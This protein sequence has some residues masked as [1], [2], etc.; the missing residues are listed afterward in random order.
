M[1]TLYPI[2]PYKKSSYG[3]ENYLILDSESSY[4]MGIFIIRQ[5]IVLYILVE[6]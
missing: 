4:I 5:Q 6:I 2:L 3:P 1:Y